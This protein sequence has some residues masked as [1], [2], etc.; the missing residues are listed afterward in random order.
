MIR[1]ATAEDTAA[2]AALYAEC[3]PDSPGFRRRV[4]ELIYPNCETLVWADEADGSISSMV[5]LPQL[6]LSDGRTAGYIYALCTRPQRRGRGL[7]TQMLD[8]AHRLCA[9]RGNP[10]TLLVPASARL[11]ETYARFGYAPLS[12]LNCFE[13]SAGNG[14]A[15]RRAVPADF[16]RIDRIYRAQSPGQ[17]RLVRPALLYQTLDAL[18]GGNGG[19]FYVNDSGGYVFIDAE[20]GITVR[21]AAALDDLPSLLRAVPPL[22]G[23]DRVVCRL[24]AASGT[25]YVCARNFWPDGVFPSVSLINLLFD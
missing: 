12:F 25:P 2:L 16:Q 9:A 21:E 14:P 7:M 24:P 19:G 8:A 18:Y 13:V 4:F 17:L 20:D 11:F 15:L 5:F 3:F 6:R 22:F 1:H 23:L 10:L